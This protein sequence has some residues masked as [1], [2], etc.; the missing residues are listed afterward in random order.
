MIAKTS[1]LAS[2][3][4]L[5]ALTLL[6]ACNAELDGTANTIESLEPRPGQTNVDPR[7]T[8]RIQL[9]SPPP[10]RKLEDMV[11]VFD[12]QGREIPGAV[13]RQNMGIVF[14]PD[15]PLPDGQTIKVCVS[16]M[17]D[18]QGNKVEFYR[19]DPELDAMEWWGTTHCYSF[20][21][22]PDLR[23]TKTFLDRS[24]PSL[25]IYFS[26]QVASDSLEGVQVRLGRD[27]PLLAT[28][29]RY[30][31]TLFRLTLVLDDRINPDQPLVVTL[32]ATVHT[33]DGRYLSHPGTLALVVTDPTE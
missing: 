23:V 5:A 8:I 3:I 19:F 16:N 14:I 20:G 17:E 32:P 13:E 31:P 6:G 10:S 24:T 26:R 21:I 11:Q 30:N 1:F 27:G 9:A 4:G 18:S 28:R 25:R 15:A 33:P 7:T 12:G 22:L 29:I 2:V